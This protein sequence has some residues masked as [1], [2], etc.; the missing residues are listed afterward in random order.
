MITSALTPY[1]SLLGDPQVLELSLAAETHKTALSKRRET[2]LKTAA[3]VQNLLAQTIQRFQ[4]SSLEL[5]KLIAK[6]QM[7][8]NS[9]KVS[10]ENLIRYFKQ[11]L[12]SASNLPSHEVWIQ[13]GRHKKRIDYLQ[14]FI[15]H[16]S[17]IE[18]RI[19]R[20]IAKS[21]YS[22]EEGAIQIK[23][24]RDNLDQLLVT[25]STYLKNPDAHV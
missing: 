23:K 16:C 20:L 6:E 21:Y 2:A 24:G 25:I 17:D 19:P 7:R 3:A 10:E 9:L 5:D 1:L 11:N 8:N 15:C 13:R 18:Y 14:C 22:A 12:T 4:E